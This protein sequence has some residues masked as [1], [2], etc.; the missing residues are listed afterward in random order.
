MELADRRG[1]GYRW[2]SRHALNIGDR[3]LA[4]PPRASPA[5]CGGYEDAI[6]WW[7]SFS[8]KRLE[9][10]L[11]DFEP[12]PLPINVVYHEGRRGAAKVHAFVDMAVERLRA[13]KSLK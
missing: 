9:I 13:D 8:A 4:N 6:H 5:E 11:A 10:V 7:V 1:I 12:K 3:L 2:Q